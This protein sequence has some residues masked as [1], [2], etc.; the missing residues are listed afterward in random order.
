MQE[1]EEWGI[2]VGKGVSVDFLL[3]NVLILRFTVFNRPLSYD[4]FMF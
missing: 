4:K 2:H 1:N 3:V